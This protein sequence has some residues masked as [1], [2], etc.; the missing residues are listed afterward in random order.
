VPSM[1]RDNL[2]TTKDKGTYCT[3]LFEREAIRFLEKNRQK[4]F[5]LYLPFN[6][7]HGA[8]NL[9]PTIRSGAQAPEKFKKMYSELQD[10]LGTQERKRYG[11]TFTVPNR[12]ARR[13]EFVGSV[14]AMDAAIGKLLDLLDRYKIAGNTIVIFFSD[15][16]GGGAADN[17]PLRGNKGQMFEGGIRVPC[18]VRWPGKIPAG[19]T[20]N[21]FL[22]SLEIFPMLCAASGTK[23][24]QSN[25]LDGFDMLG[26]LQGTK[27]SPRQEMFWQRRLDKGARVGHWKW[28]E[29]GRGNGLF[30]LRNDVAEKKDLSKERPE[31]LKMMKARFANWKKE[32]QAAEPRGPFRDF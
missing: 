20:S 4:P 15:N 31:I 17:K 24:P 25:T 2:P 3:D 14:T 27:K 7:P 13:L 22:T 11:K 23:P 32:M 26:V 1:Y 12:A 9:D 16:G 8:S 29:S 30:D 18:I 5:F 28:V 19:S 10:Q 6:A 21:E